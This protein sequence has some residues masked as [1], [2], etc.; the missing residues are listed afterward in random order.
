M[1]TEASLAQPFP[2]HNHSMGVQGK[3]EYF[4]TRNV[5]KWRPVLGNNIQT[6]LLLYLKICK[7]YHSWKICEVYYGAKNGY[8]IQD[9]TK[10]SSFQNIRASLVVIKT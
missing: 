9:I 5:V 10:H 3:R 4:E 7:Q 8:L 6:F 1:S 2:P